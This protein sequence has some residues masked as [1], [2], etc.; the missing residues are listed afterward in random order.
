MAGLLPKKR[1]PE[2]IERAD[3]LLL[4]KHDAYFQAWLQED[5]RSSRRKQS[6][7]SKD[8]ELIERPQRKSAEK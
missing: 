7:L 2:E 5:R 3:T 8:A 4:K 1:S 6:G